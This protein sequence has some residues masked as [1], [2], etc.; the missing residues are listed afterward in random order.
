MV[1]RY[2]IYEWNIL[3]NIPQLGGRKQSVTIPKAKL[4]F[5]VIRQT[6]DASLPTLQADSA[7]KMLSLANQWQGYPHM[8]QI[9]KLHKNVIAC[10][11]KRPLISTHQWV[12]Q[13]I[14]FQPVR[15]RW[16]RQA[17]N[18][19]LH[20]NQHVCKSL[21]ICS[22]NSDTHTGSFPTDLKQQ[23]LNIIFDWSSSQSLVAHGW[24]HMTRPGCRCGALEG[25]PGM[26]GEPGTEGMVHF[27][28]TDFVYIYI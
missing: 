10:I 2:I 20:G 23:H 28:I 15:P 5:V 11:S 14:R 18:N 4:H 13:P 27:V 9:Y 21:H 17:P 8:A 19:H 22:G 6:R 16:G 1:H 25:R 7:W 26:R 12:P 3:W 24:W